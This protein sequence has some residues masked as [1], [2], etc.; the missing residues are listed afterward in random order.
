MWNTHPLNGRFSIS[1]MCR[2][3]YAVVGSSQPNSMSFFVVGLVD[4]ADATDQV[5]N[6]KKSTNARVSMPSD[7]QIEYRLGAGVLSNDRRSL[8]RASR[9]T[10]RHERSA[11]AWTAPVRGSKASRADRLAS[12]E[13]SVRDGTGGD[14]DGLEPRRFAGQLRQQQ[15]DGRVGE[16]R[17]VL[18]AAHDGQ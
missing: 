8:R 14:D 2:F 17:D 6:T 12:L 15:V 18:D 3:M 11:T 7:L 10:H 13:R 16:H 1:A 4:C 9:I 5:K